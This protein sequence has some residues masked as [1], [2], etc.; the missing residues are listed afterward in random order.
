MTTCRTP[1]CDRPVA[2]RGRDGHPR[3]S[4]CVL[5]WSPATPLPPEGILAAWCPPGWRRDSRG[6]PVMPATGKLLFPCDPEDVPGVADVAQ[7]VRA[8]VEGDPAYHTDPLLSLVWAVLSDAATQKRKG[9][10]GLS[11]DVDVALSASIDAICR[12]RGTVRIVRE[13]NGWRECE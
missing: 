11:Q 8:M 10:K 9:G 13:G 6:R 4:P 2:W 5:D 12:R 1:G 7:Q 3:C